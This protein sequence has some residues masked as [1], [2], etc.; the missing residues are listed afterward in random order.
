[1]YYILLNVGI[2]IKY[3]AKVAKE[4]SKSLMLISGRYKNGKNN[5]IT[6]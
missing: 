1:M 3:D 4:Y 6:Y 2:L 5:L